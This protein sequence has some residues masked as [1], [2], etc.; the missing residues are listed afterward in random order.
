MPKRVCIEGIGRRCMFDYGSNHTTSCGLS[1]RSCLFP[2][3]SEQHTEISRSTGVDRGPV[4]RCA[5]W[6]ARKERQIHNFAVPRRLVLEVIHRRLYRL[7]PAS[8]PKNVAIART[9]E[10]SF[11]E[12]RGAMRLRREQFVDVR[13]TKISRIYPTSTRYE[14][15]S[16]PLTASELECS[17]RADETEPQIRHYGEP[18]LF[19]RSR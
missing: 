7:P 11:V 18:S 10:R 5:D 14:P 1:N 4:I 9:T 12:H 16:V 3:H 13:N 15:P 17:R 8:L 6:R 19:R 2:D